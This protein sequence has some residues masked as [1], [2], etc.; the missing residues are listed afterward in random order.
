L[1]ADRVRLN[2][3]NHDARRE[4][5]ERFNGP[6]WKVPF[7][8]FGG[9]IVTRNMPE[10]GLRVGMSAR[11]WSGTSGRMSARKATRSNFST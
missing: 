5:G 11:S 1:V 8:M 9:V 7:E 2:P 3:R 4:G 6:G 10:L